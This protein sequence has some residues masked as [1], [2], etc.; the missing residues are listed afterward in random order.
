MTTTF[1]KIH[2]GDLAPDMARFTC[3]PEENGLQVDVMKKLGMLV[4]VPAPAPDSPDYYEELP[5]HIRR[6]VS[7]WADWDDGRA[8]CHPAGERPDADLLTAARRAQKRWTPCATGDVGGAAPKGI[9]SYKLE[10]ARDVILWSDE[11]SAALAHYRHTTGGD[12]LDAICAC[13]PDLV[14][15][16]TRREL[17]LLEQERDEAFR[18]WE[19]WITFLS[20]SVQYIGVAVS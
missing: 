17:Q 8:P 15:Q 2:A 13:L 10:C 20:E 3:T 16:P 9:P 4:D 1:D 19:R 6:R 18:L 5:A 7:H 11:I 14:G 12:A